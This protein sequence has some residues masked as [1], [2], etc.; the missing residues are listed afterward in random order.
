MQFLSCVVKFSYLDVDI[1]YTFPKAHKWS[2][3]GENNLCKVELD[4]IVPVYET[5]SIICQREGRNACCCVQFW[6]KHRDIEECW[7]IG[8]CVHIWLNIIVHEVPSA[9]ECPVLTPVKHW[10]TSLFSVSFVL[11]TKDICFITATIN[12]QGVTIC[13]SFESSGKKN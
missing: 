7:P 8:Y 9:A 3:T 10:S 12:V 6:I 1:K 4:G 11:V 5:E 13:S 2:V